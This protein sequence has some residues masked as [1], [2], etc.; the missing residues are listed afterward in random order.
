MDKK[1]VSLI[2]KVAK[3]ELCIQCKKNP[4][5][6]KKNQLC[7]SCY[8]TGDPGIIFID[9]VQDKHSDQLGK[10]VTS[11]P[12]GEQFIEYVRSIFPDGIYLNRQ[13]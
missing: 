9:K 4:I 8:Q 10:I 7:K 6:I 3:V 5:D 13:W 12:C 11:V 1:L 2:E